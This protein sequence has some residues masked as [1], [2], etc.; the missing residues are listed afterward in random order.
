MSSADIFQ[1]LMLGAIALGGALVLVLGFAGGLHFEPAIRKL[2]SAWLASILLFA[3]GA[4]T[5]VSGR[6][7]SLYGIGDNLMALSVSG[8]S[9]WVLRLST[10]V[11]VGF[12]SLIVASALLG[13]QTP[14]DAARPLFL[15]FSLY[16]F[17][18][19]VFSGLFGTV[20]SISYKTFYPFL[21]VFALYITSDYEEELLLRL[22]RRLVL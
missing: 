22:V 13:K 12:S 9:E 1:S 16:F 2:A 10:A 11:A 6:N 3:L 14:Q 7:A 15:A 4:S 5:L 8:Y 19:Y 18:T 20:F 21:V 17:A